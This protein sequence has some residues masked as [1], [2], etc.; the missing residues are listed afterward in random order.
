MERNEHE[1]AIR[2][3]MQRVERQA[4]TSREVGRILDAHG[5]T[6]VAIAAETGASAQHVSAWRDPSAEK[7]LSIADA[8]ALP[9]AARRDLMDYLGRGELQARTAPSAGEALDVTTARALLRRATSA[10]DA[11]F[12]ALEDGRV[13]PSEARSVGEHLEGLAFAADALR[14]SLARAAEVPA[15]TSK[16]R[17]VRA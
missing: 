6:A 3:K 2:A 4:E 8:S 17:A 11:A 12:A 10:V 14:V 9:L 7:N 5:L 16:L 13:D 15:P 1:R